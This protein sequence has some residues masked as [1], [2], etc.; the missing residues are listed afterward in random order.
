MKRLLLVLA[1]FQLTACSQL[2]EVAKNLPN[3]GGAISNDQIA[4]GLKAALTKGIDEEVSKLAQ[5]NGFYSNEKLRIPLPKK[6]EKVE[7]GLRSIGLG[8]LADKGIKALNNAAEDAVGEATPIFINAV[9]DMTVSDA[10]SVLL[11]QQN[12]A[13][14]YL[15]SKTSQQ[16]YQKF[17]PVISN[18]F[19]KV[20]AERI[21]NNIIKRYNQIPLTEKVNP[22]LTDYVTQQALGGVFTAIADEERHKTKYFRTHL[23]PAPA[24]LCLAG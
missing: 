17:Q 9:K 21:W 5:E 14:Q 7:Q 2:Q 4:Q 15:E 24:C 19:Q 8:N 22:D 11:G 13:T 10:R 23:F 16:L 3:Q 12:A 18:S 6:L 20:G 1:I